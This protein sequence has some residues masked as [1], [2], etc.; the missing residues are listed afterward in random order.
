MNTRVVCAMVLFVVLAGRGA[1]AAGPALSLVPWPQKVQVQEG[2]LAITA[3]SRIVATDAKLKPLAAVLA[4]EI[5]AC[6][7]LK[8]TAADGTPKAGDI[9]LGMDSAMKGEQHALKVADTAAVTG[10]TY[11]AV[12][13]GT[14][15]L[16]Q[17]LAAQKA[18][19]ASLPKM[20]VTD[21]PVCPYRGVMID[22]ARR[23][24]SIGAL[25]QCVVMCRLY[26][27]RYLQLHLTDDHAWTFPS[28][29][30]P[31]LGSSNR[32]YNGP[33]PK[34][35]KL[36]DLEALVRFADERGVTIVPEI[37]VPGH[38]DALRIPYPEIFDAADG[39]AHMAIVDMTNPKA[40]EGVATIIGEMCQVFKS[41][42]YFHFGADEPRLDRC[43]VSPTYKS[44][45][46]KNGLKD[47]YDLF[48]HWI[49][50]MDKVVKKNGRK[51]LVWGDFHAPGSEHAAVP[52]DVTVICWQNGS[53]AAK[54]FTEKGY[55]VVNATWNPLYVVNQT[56]ETLPKFQEDPGFSPQTLFA[57]NRFTFDKLTL[58][59][60]PRVLGAQLC[61]WEEG[62]EIQVPA[63][64]SRVAPM[65][66]RIWNPEA[67]KDWDDFRA[68]AS[69]TDAILTKLIA[70]IPLDDDK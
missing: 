70:G 63:L 57:W 61:A 15:T 44:F 36:D 29:A 56:L 20:T 24:N 21:E 55:N 46:Q 35:Y 58:K 60:T 41:S 2:R 43:S 17:A 11:Q 28:R 49:V 32:G 53:N 7:G 69:A 64:R 3:A 40:Y 1:L 37:D 54:D 65:S 23:Y 22:V 66:E 47:E 8:L 14:V 51:T 27:I 13:A 4:G 39:P 52:K 26:K 25:R 10:G 9:V 42:P 45:I 19:A 68:R 18:A 31:K 6:A 67:G 16:L 12:A 34:V 62:G 33:A 38:T 48:C 59:P 5:E 50:A 30:F